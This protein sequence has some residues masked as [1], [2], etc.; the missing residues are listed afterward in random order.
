M[1]TAISGVPWLAEVLLDGAED[2]LGLALPGDDLDLHAG[3]PTRSLDQVF[4]VLRVPG[5]TGRGSDEALGA[6]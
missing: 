1:S 6:Q 2:Q 5:R 3:D 4:A